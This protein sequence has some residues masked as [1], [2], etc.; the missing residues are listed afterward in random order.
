MAIHIWSRD[1]CPKPSSSAFKMTK[2]P[3][4]VEQWPLTEEKL[5]ALEHRGKEQLDAGP[6]PLGSVRVCVAKGGNCSTGSETTQ[7]ATTLFLAVLSVVTVQV[8]R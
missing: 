7:D 4:R 8:A 6:P 1:H 3:V 2:K 5:Q